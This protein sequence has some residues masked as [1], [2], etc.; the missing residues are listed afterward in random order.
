MS[1][2]FGAARRA[3][4]V[5]PIGTRPTALE[6]IGRSVLRLRLYYGWSQATLEDRSK[7]DQT[8]I[9]R[10]ERGAQR[11][12]SIVRLAAILHV[13]RV[14]EIDFDPPRLITPQTDLEIM[15]S[16][17]WWLA[18]VREADRRLDWPAT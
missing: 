11:G 9:S 4:R 7:V 2:S 15:L 3:Q 1:I 16:G 6:K 14:G 10:L 18:A 12:L 17:D 8:T 5:R 13:L